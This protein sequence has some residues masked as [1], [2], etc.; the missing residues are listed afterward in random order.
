MLNIRLFLNQLYV[1]NSLNFLYAFLC[2][3]QSAYKNIDAFKRRILKP[4]IEEINQK[5][6]LKI[7]F[8]DLKCEFNNKTIVGFEFSIKQSEARQIIVHD[9]KE[10]KKEAKIEINNNSDDDKNN[11][12][13]EIADI[14]EIGIKPAS[15]ILEWYNKDKNRLLANW[16]EVSKN[17]SD[18]SNAEKAKLMAYLW[19][20][21]ANYISQEEIIVKEKELANSLKK[22]AEIEE[23]KKKEAEYKKAA[24]IKAKTKLS[25]T[26]KKYNKLS[27]KEKLQICTAV[28]RSIGLKLNRCTEDEAY[29]D[30]S[31]LST[32][33]KYGIAEHFSIITKN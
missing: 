21:N 32:A 12:P 7:S 2:N 5:T 26:E 17:Y 23:I 30:F 10:I 19:K 25:D 1:F 9:I 18:K 4:A 14:A 22:Q 11:Y 16:Q 6:D 29:L 27:Q 20:I 31:K 3:K 24:E 8:E 15:K 28:A 33:Y 13:Q